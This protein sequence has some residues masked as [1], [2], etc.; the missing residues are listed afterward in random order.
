[1][2]KAEPPNASSSAASA[3]ALPE[4]GPA[5]PPYIYIVIETDLEF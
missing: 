1:M 2:K 4:I 5:L 3:I